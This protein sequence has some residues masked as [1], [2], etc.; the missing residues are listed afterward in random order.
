MSYSGS[1]HKGNSGVIESTEALLATIKSGVRGIRLNGTTSVVCKEDK[2]RGNRDN[3]DEIIQVKIPIS[4]RNIRVSH[5]IP[6]RIHEPEA[7][8]PEHA[9]QAPESVRAQRSEWSCLRQSVQ[10][11]L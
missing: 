1:P 7:T 9:N 6:R 10:H 4:F 11:L 3:K 2:K 8:R 5:T